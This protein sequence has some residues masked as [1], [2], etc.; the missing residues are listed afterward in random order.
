MFKDTLPADA[1]LTDQQEYDLIGAMYEAR[2]ALPASSLMNNQ[3]SDP[4]QLTEERIAETL[5]QLEQL[6][7]V[8][9]NRAAAILTPAQL[10]QFTK[11]QQQLSTM[12]AAGLKMAVQ[13]FG[14]KGAP[15]PPAAN[16]G[17]TP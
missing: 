17:P 10:E 1:A 6:Q 2:K 5:K 4:S 15:Q 11:W 9:A 14:N 13:M 16:Q 3:N 8:Y 7:Q 12:Q